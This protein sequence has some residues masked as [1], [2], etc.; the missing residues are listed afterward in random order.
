MNNALEYLEWRGDLMPQT[1]GINEVDLFLCSQLAT[2]DY[3]GIV[4]EKGA[5]V[6]IPEASALF[7]RHNPLDVAILGALQ[8][9]SVLP[10]LKA[11]PKY[12][13]F[14]TA[15]LGF[16][17]LKIDRAKEEQF[18]AVSVF[19]ADGSVVVSYQGTD[20]TIVGWKE[21]FN[22]AVRDFVPAQHDAALYLERV[23][24]KT[25]GPLYV[26]G[27][28]K[29]GNLAVYAAA[30][31]TRKVRDRI[32]RVISFDGPGFRDDF[33]TSRGY[34]AIADRTDAILSQNAMVGVLL[35]PVGRT[36]IVK[37]HNKGV[38]AHDG[39]SWEVK[40]DRFV[41][42]SSF[43]KES[44]FFDKT[45]DSLIASLSPEERAD[46]IN[47]LFDALF[48]TGSVT[49]T[50]LKRMKFNQVFLVVRRFA[51][52]KRLSRTISVMIGAGMFVGQA[53][54]LV[55]Q[56]YVSMDILFLCIGVPFMA[57]SLL[58]LMLKVKETKD[59]DLDNV[60]ADTFR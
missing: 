55:L 59:V 27:H 36:V 24:A 23:A 29:G 53:L 30:H 11:L 41:R 56:N 17:V 54:F 44:L 13:R 21:N 33:V 5:P 42:C 38:M 46:F 28:S 6:P 25:E 47:G 1:A 10:M 8:S 39:F 7:F 12:P 14:A 58:L 49:V 4:S 2:P 40:G 9:E 31:S 35:R 18:S 15:S 19:F 48:A 32:V 37:S 50:D 16:Y 26:V 43:S 45:M 3:T 57:V 51:V 20:D 34:A 22:I 52:K 60:T